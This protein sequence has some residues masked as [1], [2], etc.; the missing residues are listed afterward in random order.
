MG[1]DICPYICCIFYVSQ[2]AIQTGSAATAASERKS[3]KYSDRV[4]LVNDDSKHVFC[5]VAVETVSAL[6][7]DVPVFPAEIGWRA[8][9]CTPD[10]WETTFLY[11][12]IFGCDSAV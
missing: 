6:A 9:L 12:R 4:S 2:S 8:T 3:A 7:D 1:R 5:P 10:P 11:Q